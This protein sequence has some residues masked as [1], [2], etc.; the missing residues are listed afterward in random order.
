MKWRLTSLIAVCLSLGLF[1]TAA[2][3]LY[4]DLNSTNPTP[5]YADLPTAAT[6]IQD[7]VD[8]ST[9]GDLILVN[10]GVYQDGYAISGQSGGGGKGGGLLSTNRVAVTKPVMVQSLNG[11]GA[12]YMD[13]GDVYRCVFLANGATL[14]G[15]TLQN[16]AVGWV[17]TTV[18]FGHTNST[19]NAV[20][21]GGVAGLM[22]PIPSLYQGVVSNCLLTGNTATGFGGGAS[23]VTLINCTLT[24]NAAIAGGGAASC[25]LWNCIVNGNSAETNGTL[26]IGPPYP[27][28]ASA[29][30]GGICSSTAFN[31]LIEN[32][33]AFDG[34]GAY[35]THL[36]NCTIVNN[37]AAFGGGVDEE[38]T[39]PGSQ[40]VYLWVTN[41]IIY[42]NHAG[43]GGN[44]GS[45][46]LAFDNCCVTPLPT[47]GIGNFT[48]DPAFEDYWDSDFHLQSTSPCI[49]G[50]DNHA[51]N[52]AFDL[53][54]NPRIVGGT[55]DIGA[56]EFQTP[57]SVLGY[58]WAQQYGLPVDGS[59]DYADT[60]GDGM[61]NWQEFIAGT[62]PINAASV[63]A[64]SPVSFNHY[65][66]WVLVQWQGVNT[67]TYYLE[68][69]SDLTTGF[70][71]ISSNIVG[72]T[73]T[74]IYFDTTA[75]NGGPYYYRVGVQ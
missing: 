17:Q 18:E 53:D 12:A 21:G 67:R 70:T 75:T 55:V 26:I 29:T 45:G 72:N 14:S 39:T 49:N 42:D 66:N 31:C 38:Q 32:N 54:G 13:G 69:S 23:G 10:D 71:C 11:P 3:T 22:L 4:V 60:D 9:N 30:G 47:V 61:N 16:G 56:Y 74:T 59:A 51:V 40:V 41:C 35:E 34:G 68:R 19:T 36:V 63:L 57:I 2:S 5:P 43:S 62:N 28:V 52:S 8:A 46:N 15:F 64:M 65:L 33:N 20:D 73:G 1:P 37:T 50:G 7:A 27:T 25:N 24:G 58:L 48:N 6:N 44:Y